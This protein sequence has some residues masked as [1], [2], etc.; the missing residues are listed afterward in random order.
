MAVPDVSVCNPVIDCKKDVPPL[1]SRSLFLEH[2]SSHSNFV[3]IFTDGSKSDTGVGFSVVFPTFCRGGSLPAVSSVFTA[4]LSAI[5]L[6]LQLIFTLPINSFQIFSDSRSALSALVT[7]HPTVHPLVLSALEWFYLLC[8]RGYRVGF[9]WVPGHVGVPGNERADA[10][11]REAA[12]RVALPSSVSCSDLF[13]SIR[14]ATRTSWQ[15]CW[16]EQRATSKMGEIT[17]SVTP[18]WASNPIR[19]RRSQTALTRLRIGHTRLTHSYLMSGDP[20]P[21]CEDCL[22]PLTVR[23]LLVECPSLGDLR[24]RFLYRCRGSDGAFQ[25][26]SILGPSCLNPGFDVLRFIEE[27]GF[28]SSL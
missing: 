7:L 9:C 26:S 5:V 10:L 19:D 21:D 13:L 14:V 25:L 20:Q 17:T 4:E 23:H 16:D 12:A 11:A 1:V 24:C 3:P 6:A 2:Y 27:A 8:T 22:V 15:E 28:L 18:P